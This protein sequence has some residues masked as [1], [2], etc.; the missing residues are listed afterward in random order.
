LSLG[1]LDREGFATQLGDL[2]LEPL[3]G[4]LVDLDVL[5][6]LSDFRLNGTE[7]LFSVFLLP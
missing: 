1:I 5:H 3:E 4:L 2:D 7:I 6:E